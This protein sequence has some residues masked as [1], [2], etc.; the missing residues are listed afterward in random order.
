MFTGHHGA[1]WRLP[2]ARTTLEDAIS[3]ARPSEAAKLDAVFPANGMA[4][5]LGDHGAARHRCPPAQAAE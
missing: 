2:S 3:F 4:A 1:A 5:R